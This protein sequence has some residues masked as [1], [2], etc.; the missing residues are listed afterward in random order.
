MVL[1]PESIV[2]NKGEP[3]DSMYFIAKGELSVR[4][5][6]DQR[7]AS[8][9]AGNF[10]GELAIL[11]GG[12]RSATIKTDTYSHV[13]ELERQAFD[14]ITSMHL[15]T[16][17]AIESVA[18]ARLQV[19]VRSAPPPSPRRSPQSRKASAKTLPGDRKVRGRG[20][21]G[22]PPLSPRIPPP[23][24]RHIPVLPRLTHSTARPGP[25]PGRPTPPPLPSQS[26]PTQGLSI[27][28]ERFVFFA[29]RA[30]GGCQRQDSFDRQRLTRNRQRLALHRRR[31][32][33]H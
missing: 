24:P 33:L 18:R 17:E 15:G 14:D 25:Y 12:T 21:R 13:Y 16:R 3:G 19:A 9:S 5:E 10:F 6:K 2:I 28:N 7:V 31:L 29:L 8:L 4:N 22:S 1:L 23:P 30:A 32:A 27:R 20:T 26:H 11:F